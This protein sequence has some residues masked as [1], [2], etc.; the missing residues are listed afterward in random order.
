MRNSGVPSHSGFSHFRCEEATV[1]DV[2]RKLWTVKVVTRFTEKEPADV[3]VLSPYLHYAGGEGIHHLPEPGAKCYIA[4]PS[5]NT[6][7]FIIGYKG[8]AAALSEEEGAAVSFR[9]RRPRMDPGDIGFTGR[10]GN[11]VMLRRGG[12]VEV[13]CS[14]L[15][16]RIYLPVRNTIR[17][18]SEN[19]SQSTLAGDV[20]WHV[21][22]VENDP[23]GQAK[24]VHIFHMHEHAQD[25]KASVRIAHYGTPPEGGVSVAYDILVAPTGIDKQTGDFSGAVY[26]LSILSDGTVNAMSAATTRNVDGSD[27]VNASGDITYS[28]DGNARFESAGTTTIK[29]RDVVLDGRTLLGSSA[30]QSPAVRGERLAQWWAAQVLVV[31]LATMTAKPNPASIPQLQRAFSTKVFLE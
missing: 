14:A 25:A 26:H 17:D 4:F 12:V 27:I 6:P 23:D 13:G 2:N 15:A 24:A 7:P 1:V 22:R 10:D 3:Q 18:Y 30:A 11:F 16:Q 31:D 29:G 8:V 21:E 5:D 19:Y 9:S 28:A 20:S